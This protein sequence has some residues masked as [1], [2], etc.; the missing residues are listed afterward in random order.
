MAYGDNR[1][2]LRT[3]LIA[4][5]IQQLVNDAAQ[6]GVLHVYSAG[7][8][9]PEADATAYA[10]VGGWQMLQDDNNDDRVGAK[11][12]AAVQFAIEVGTPEGPSDAV[13]GL[14]VYALEDAVDRV[15]DAVT[16]RASEFQRARGGGADRCRLVTFNAQASF[17]V[18]SAEADSRVATVTVQARAESIEPIDDPPSQ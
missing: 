10:H 14:G 15:L 5:A 11:E 2:R 8:A 9:R 17:D 4:P 16:Q 13:D 7:E 18:L 1:M 6:D 3:S 12:G